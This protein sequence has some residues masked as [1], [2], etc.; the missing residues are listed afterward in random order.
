M[1]WLDPFITPIRDIRD[2]SPTVSVPYRIIKK[3]SGESQKYQDYDINISNN[4]E[5]D[6]EQ[7]SDDD[8]DEDWY[9]PINDDW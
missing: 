5:Q 2:P 9:E 3:S 6:N 7:G 4:I 1:S 8:S